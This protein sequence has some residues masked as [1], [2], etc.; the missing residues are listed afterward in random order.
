MYVTMHNYTIGSGTQLD[1][2]REA[3]SFVAEAASIA[4][5][6]ALYMIDAGDSVIAAVAVFDT[7]EGIEECDRRAAEFVE[8]RLAGFQLSSPEVKQGQVL[9]SGTSA[10]AEAAPART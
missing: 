7:R 10:A 9:A 3:Q 8:R 4:G 2:A 6:R 5:F 1:L